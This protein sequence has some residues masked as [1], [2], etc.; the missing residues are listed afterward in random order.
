[1]ATNADWLSQNLKQLGYTYFQ[2]DE[3]YQYARGEYTTADAAL[4][5]DGLNHIANEVTHDG[6]TF[7]VWTAPF[8]VS[9]RAWVYQNHK[10]WLVHNAAGAPLHI[11]YVTDGQEPL[12]V[13][14]TTHPGAQEY[15]RQTYTT[16]REMGVRFIKMDFMDDTAVEGIYFRPNTTALEAQRIG[17]QI[18]RAAVG[19]QVVL[20]KDGSPMLNPVGLVDAGRISQDTGHTFEATRDAASGVAA[21]YYMNRNFF[22]ADP[23]AFTVS[24]QTVTDQSWHGG[25][26]PLTLAE[27]QVSIALSAVSGGMFEIGDDLPTLGASAERLSLVRNPDLLDVAQLGRASRPMDLLSYADRDLQPSVFLLVENKRQVLLT[28]FNWTQESRTRAINLAQLGLR[29]SYAAADVFG[30]EGCCEVSSG[31]LNLEQPPH[32]VRMLKLID[33]S[34]PDTA[35]GFEVRAPEHLATGGTAMFEAQAASGDDPIVRCHWNF[36]DGTS[37][38]GVRVQHAYTASGNYA[39]EVTA[40][41]LNSQ[42]SHKTQQ[43]AVDGAVSTRFDPSRNRR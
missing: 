39:V 29:G 26:R 36:G 35:P 24:T 1:M 42:A 15:L 8:E 38:D 43:V 11:G 25:Q 22:I 3:G 20:D 14:D 18:I 31:T 28:V 32:S 40:T 34:I 9:E 16:L 17:L 41:G 2:I 10:D 30:A 6:L 4:F 13:L 7:G 19:E 12:Y 21:R 33:K 23:D 37:A 27:A 5:P